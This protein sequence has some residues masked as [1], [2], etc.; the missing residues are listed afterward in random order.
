MDDI[1][2]FNITSFSGNARLIWHIKEGKTMKMTGVW[3]LACAFVLCLVL[4]PIHKSALAESSDIEV[5]KTYYLEC[6]LHADPNKNKLSSVNY[7]L[8]GKVLKWGTPIKIKKISK[9]KVK[10]EASGE[11][12]T[13]EIHKRTRKITT[14]R[15]HLA[16][17]LT[18]DPNKLKTRV[19]SLS[20]VDKKGIEDARAMVGMS[21]Q[22]VLIAIG[23]P[24]EFVVTDPMAASS[25]Q[26][27]RNR[28]GKFVVIFDTHAKVKDIAGNY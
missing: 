13:Y 17:F 12:F 10:F 21:K 18:T 4:M 24:P 5:G 1:L 9:G 11:N 27:W 3:S 16:R 14:V 28:W 19:G 6:N 22:G 20:S 25:W 8:A 15:D 26:Y 2:T 23:Y 7:Q